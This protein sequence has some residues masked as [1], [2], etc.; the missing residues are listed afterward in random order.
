VE[1][2]EWVEWECE[3]IIFSPKVL[4]K[5]NYKYLLTVCKLVFLD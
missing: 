5:M 3:Q 4:Y 1:W 2:E